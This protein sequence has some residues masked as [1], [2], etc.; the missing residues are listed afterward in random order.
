MERN[1]HFRVL[2]IRF[3]MTER[4]QAIIPVV[5]FLTS[6]GYQILDL[7]GIDLVI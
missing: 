4:T 7:F 6:K 2:L 1:V 3:Q 5:M